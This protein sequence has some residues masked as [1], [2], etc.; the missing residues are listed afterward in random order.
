MLLEPSTGSKTTT[1]S[2]VTAASPQS[3]IPAFSSELIA[4]TNPVESNASATTL[5]PMTSSFCCSS[6][7]TLAAPADPKKSRKAARLISEEIYLPAD[8]M[9][10]SSTAR[11]EGL[12]NSSLELSDA[13]WKRF[14]GVTG[15]VRKPRIRRDHHVFSCLNYMPLLAI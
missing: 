3:I 14:G 13:N 8:P 9:A 6:P 7:V 12:A 4:Q 10:F 1:Y 5:S 15:I 2:P 11:S